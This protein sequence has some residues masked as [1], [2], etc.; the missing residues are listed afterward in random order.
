MTVDEMLAEQD[1]IMASAGDSGDLSAEQVT[2]YEEL[3]GL[4][5]RGRQTEEIQRRHAA[6]RAAVTRPVAAAQN[7][8][9][10]QDQLERAFN[11]YL[12]TGKENAD[13][14]ELR[15]QNEGTGSAGG[16]LVPDRFRQKLVERLKA[17]GGLA[18]VVDEFS[19]GDGAPV[20]WPTLDDTAN[21]GEIVAEGG[22]F[23]SGAD[24]VFGEANLGAYKYMSG[25]AGGTGLRVSWEL[26]QDSAFDIEGLVSRKLGERIAR[27]QAQHLVRGTGVGQPLGIVTG[28]TGIQTAANN[29]LTYADL[30]TYM[31]SIDPAY[32]ANARWA[33]NDAALAVIQK[34]IDADGR[35]LLQSNANGSIAN[36]PGGYTLLGKPV[37]I[38]QA[39]S[40]FNNASPT[41][42]WGVY[43]DLRAGYVVRR[44][45][46]VTVVVDPY[47]RATNG[48]VQYT[49]WA[50]MDA[51]QQDTNAY[52]ALTGKT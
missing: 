24:M 40:N 19:T 42:N 8:A 5:Q 38:D 7:A 30:I 47:T 36:D 11:H 25:G 45:R 41:V 52:V 21:T 46:D 12:R 10:D 51:T 27:L 18:A 49:A 17:F 31:H 35:P 2:R 28:L 48:Q 1:Q 9:G 43:G 23:V 33:F 20:N 26:L 50:R 32:Q 44:V 29:A 37:T 39:F 14:Q 34:L 22:T 13:L 3:D 16:F 4:I 6:A 15:A